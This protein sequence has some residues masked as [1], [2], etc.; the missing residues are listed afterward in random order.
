MQKQFFI[1]ALTACLSMQLP[2]QDQ[3]GKSVHVQRDP[4][5]D[6]LVDLQIQVNRE[7]VKGKTIIE[8]GYRIVV[9]STNKRDQAMEVKS[10][11]MKTYP[12]QKTYLFYQS[13]HFRVQ[14]GNFRTYKDAEKMKAE[15]EVEYGKSVFIAPSKV[16]VRMDQQ[17]TEKN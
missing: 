8:Q 13:P 17:E 16:E 4:R 11:L 9:I 5:V 12:D 6:K 14:F 3:F 10:R 2:A 1:F 7:A 15:L